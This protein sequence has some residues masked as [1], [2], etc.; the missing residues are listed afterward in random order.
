MKKVKGKII[1]I[2]DGQFEKSFLEE[3][4]S[5]QD[6][7]IKVEYFSKAR[8]ALDHLKH[9]A[10][11]IFLIISDMNMPEM[12][13]M[14]FKK[15]IDEDAFLR[16]KSIPFIFTTSEVVLEEVTEAYE[17]RVQGFFK[18]PET[19]EEQASMLE[20]IVQYWRSC[21]HPNQKFSPY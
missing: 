15:T 1:L 17:Y 21:I 10:D 2:D 20:K 8:D 11:D 9:N 13:G 18:K 3:S 6:W 19:I 7:D 12:S 16:Q 4:L 5:D 14:E